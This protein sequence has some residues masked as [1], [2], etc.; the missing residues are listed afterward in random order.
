MDAA[1][2]AA[3][4]RRSSITGLQTPPPK[5]VK[6][7]HKKTPKS[8]ASVSTTTPEAKRHMSE[9]S[10]EKS[11]VSASDAR[12]VVTPQVLQ[13]V[14]ELSMPDKAGRFHISCTVPVRF[15]FPLIVIDIDIDILNYVSISYLKP[16]STVGYSSAPFGPGATFCSCTAH[17]SLGM[18]ARSSSAVLTVS[19]LSFVVNKV[20]ALAQLAQNPLF[21]QNPQCLGA[22]LQAI[23][24]RGAEDVLKEALQ[25]AKH[26]TAQTVQAEQEAPAEPQPAPEPAGPSPKLRAFWNQFK[27]KAPEEGTIPATQ[28]DDAL[29]EETPTV[30]ESTPPAV[31]VE[32]QSQEVALES[33]TQVVETQSLEAVVH[34]ETVPDQATSA[35]VS[36][37]PETKLSASTNEELGRRICAG[38]HAQGRGP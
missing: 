2:K 28:P 5:P 8:C 37:N 35:V 3:E 36:T 15:V 16:G 21:K 32:S 25:P 26:E 23:A 14:C 1:L 29:H 34:S 17:C 20:E 33:Q 22:M 9:S 10:A 24:S 31:H 6:R 12:E 4:E 19:F 7:C 18:W 27:R 30:L 11:E 13:P 38:Q